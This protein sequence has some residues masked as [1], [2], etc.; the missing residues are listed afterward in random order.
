VEVDDAAALVFGDL[1]E[2]DPELGCEGLVGQP[3]LAGE[4]PTEAD[5]ETPPQ[6]RRAGVE[7][8]RAGVVVAVRAQRFTEPGIV[9]GV[10]LAAG[11]AAAMRAVLDAPPRTAP[12]EPAVF[13]PG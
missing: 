10:L 1:G 7:Q 2:G 5:G 4:S 9:A 8:H 12:L 6:L 11:H 3:G 13:L